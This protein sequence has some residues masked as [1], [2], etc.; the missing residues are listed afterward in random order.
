M[1]DDKTLERLWRCEKKY[2]K[3]DQDWYP[4]KESLRY[5]F[6]TKDPGAG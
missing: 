2:N 4:D 6:Y 1:V 5:C 3:D